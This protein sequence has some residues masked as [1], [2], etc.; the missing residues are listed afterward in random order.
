MN[1]FEKL[2]EYIINED[3]AKAK[4]LF[5]KIVVEKSRKIYEGLVEDD[6][7]VEQG[8]GADSFGDEISDHEDVIDGDEEGMDD[9][10]GDDMGD[11]FGGDDEMGGMDDMGGD[12]GGLEDRV[13]DLED[14]IDELKSEFDRLM[15]D[16]EGGDDEFGGDGD[17]DDFGGD[18]DGDADDFGGDDE[19]DFDSDEGDDIGGDELGDEVGGDD[20]KFGEASIYGESKK[21]D[22][23]WK[24]S[25][26][27]EHSGTAVKGD[28]YTGKEAAKEENA[29]AK[30]VKESVKTP[31]DLMREYIEK[32]GSNWPN[33]ASEGDAVGSGGTKSPINSKSIS[34][35]GKND[36]GGTTANIARGGTASDKD[37]NTGP[38]KPSNAYTKGEKKMGQDKY[39]NSPAANTKGYKDKR[40]VKREQEGQTT[41]GSVPVVKKSFNPGGTPGFK[42]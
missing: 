19:S 31:N 18:D 25:K 11:D 40:T 33:G 24:D 20:K 10:M 23:P 28:K 6:F 27:K 15:G 7:P 30:K 37:S 1:K 41:D 14:A 21:T 26:G 22:K 12:E 39:E 2:I 8:D 9:D 34:I 32:V 29:K 16:E 4:A 38:K 17:A 36:M 13:M 42:G 3:E 35:N 5:H